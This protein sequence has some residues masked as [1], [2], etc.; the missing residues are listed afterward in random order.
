MRRLDLQPSQCVEHLE[1]LEL[2]VEVGLEPEH[3]RAV[4][5]RLQGLVPFRELPFCLCRVDLHAPRQVLGAYAPQRGWGQVARNRP[6]VKDVAPRQH[7]AVNT[8]QPQAGGC[9]VTVGHVQNRRQSIG[10]DPADHGSKM[11]VNRFARGC[12][13]MAKSTAGTRLT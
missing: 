4:Y 13:A 8:G 5:A 1:Q 6:F 3:V 12:S 2:V 11:R 7:A 10:S 9:A